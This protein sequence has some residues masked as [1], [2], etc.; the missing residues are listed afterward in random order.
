MR[1]G[2]DINMYFNLSQQLPPL[3][4]KKALHKEATAD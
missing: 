4:F 2:E 3:L 1:R